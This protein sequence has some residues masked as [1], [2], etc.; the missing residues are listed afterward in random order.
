M[1]VQCGHS[2]GPQPDN[3]TSFGRQ[4]LY[5][6]RHAY[7]RLR[8]TT[9]LS[10]RQF[11]LPR[12]VEKNFFNFNGTAHE[13]CPTVQFCHLWRCWQTREAKD[14]GF[15]GLHQIGRGALCLGVAVPLQPIQ[16]KDLSIV[17]ADR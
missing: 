14:L 10:E 8:I 16:D 17:Q 3:R 2:Q 4:R 12:C 5:L 13:I 1:G 7:R 9:S 11:R 6:A 15:G